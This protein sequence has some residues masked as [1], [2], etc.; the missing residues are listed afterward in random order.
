MLVLV[1]T[2]MQ[3]MISAKAGLV[4]YVD[5]QANVHLH[6]QVTAGAAIETGP[7]GHVELLLSPGSFLR[8]GE[9]SKVVLDSVE[10]SN[11]TVRIMEGAALIEAADI[12]KQTPI[13]VTSGNL[14]TLII[15]SGVYRFSDSTALV[16]DGRLRLADK[17]KTVKKGHQ[18]TLLAGNYVVNSVDGMPKDDLDSWSQQR[19]GDLAKANAVAYHDQS[20]GVSYPYGG[21]GLG[22]YGYAYGY[23]L[24]SGMY[25]PYGGVYANQPWWIYSPLLGGFTFIPRGGYRSYWGYS[26]R[27]FSAFASLPGFRPYGI[28]P[29][30]T[31][32]RPGYSGGYG[33]R[34]GSTMGGGRG[35]SGSTGGG[36]HG[37]SSRGG[38]FG[39]H[40]G[41][42]GGGGHR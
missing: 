29:P 34:P 17:S 38:G 20:S 21:Y 6:E 40:G 2:L 31:T 28:G 5:G 7:Q 9:R 19:S 30:G 3:Y 35:S 32:R 14:R 4:N 26:F 23:L 18:I 37:G 42:H 27:P 16:L 36:Y 13:H 24:Y 10:L 8:I 41:G 33:S 15:A 25:Y 39:G 11:I 1:F 12:D 22:G